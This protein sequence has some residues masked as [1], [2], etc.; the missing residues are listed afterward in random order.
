M[1]GRGRACGQGAVG[2]GL[3]SGRREGCGQLEVAVSILRKGCLPCPDHTESGTVRL[4][5]ISQF[6]SVC[7]LLFGFF[8]FNSETQIWGC[9]SKSSL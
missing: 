9:P 5:V 3:E 7:L 8:L 2:I 4:C 6:A 1:E